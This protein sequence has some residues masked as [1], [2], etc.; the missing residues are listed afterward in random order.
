MS[1]LSS[2]NTGKSSISIT[3]EMLERIG[4]T[5]IFGRKKYKKK[6]SNTQIYIDYVNHPSTNTKDMYVHLPLIHTAKG[7]QVK[8]INHYPFKICTINELE[9]VEKYFNEKD[10]RKRGKYKKQLFNILNTRTG[11][12]NLF[13]SVTTF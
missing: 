13:D 7:V 11:L 10:T 9:L 12:F 5:K 2:T 1:I 4:Y 6:L 3:I 8:F